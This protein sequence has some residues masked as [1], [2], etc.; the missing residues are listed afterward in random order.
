MLAYLYFTKIEERRPRIPEAQAK[1]FER[2]FEMPDRDS[3]IGVG[4]VD[5]LKGVQAERD[6]FRKAGVRQVNLDAVPSRA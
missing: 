5:W 2:T 1:T 4:F 6:V 3:T